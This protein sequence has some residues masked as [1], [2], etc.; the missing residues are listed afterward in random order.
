[1]PMSHYHFRLVD[2]DRTLDATGRPVDNRDQAFA[3]AKRL[4]IDIA[5]SRQEY[6][7]KGYAVAVLDDAG[8]EIHRESI[9]SAEKSG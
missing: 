4:A 5:E 7:G 8:N 2:H 3:V 9:D 1:M 6:L